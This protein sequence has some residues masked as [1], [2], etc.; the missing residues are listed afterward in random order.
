ML[1]SLGHQLSKRSPLNRPH[2]CEDIG[3]SLYSPINSVSSIVIRSNNTGPAHDAGVEE[4]VSIDSVS[5][6]SDLHCLAVSPPTPKQFPNKSTEIL[7]ALHMLY[8]RSLSN[9][10]KSSQSFSRLPFRNQ[11]NC[12]LSTS[13]ICQTVDKEVIVHN[14][15]VGDKHAPRPPVGW[16]ELNKRREILFRPEVSSPR[17]VFVTDNAML[18][19]STP[20]AAMVQSLKAPLRESTPHRPASAA[21]KLS[22]RRNKPRGESAALWTPRHAVSTK[23]KKFSAVRTLQM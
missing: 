3:M 10:N 22:W 20:R 19:S 1:Q 8:G 17:A 9:N 13:S 21:A 16:R 18:S 11:N 14:K 6:R 5:R 23:K 4:C 2:M 7:S 15:N 12:P